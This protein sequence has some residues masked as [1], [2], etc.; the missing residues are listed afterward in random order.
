MA[1]KQEENKA[2]QLPIFE[3]MMDSDSKD[4]AIPDEEASAPLDIY[5]SQPSFTMED[6]APPMLKLLQGLSPEV[7]DGTGSPGQWALAGFDPKEDMVVVPI[8]FARRREYRDPDTFALMCKS[9][10][11]ETGHGEP[12]GSCADCPMNKWNDGRPPKCQFMYSY[13]MYCADYQAGGIVNFKRTGLAA[14]KAL[15]SIMSRRG[16]GNVALILGSK[17]QSGK[18]GSYYIPQLRPMDAEEEAAVLND[19]RAF[20]APPK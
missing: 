18:K 2:E 7:S 16:F 4:L 8:S 3:G 19:S 10:D 9:F 5:T 20:F 15:N 6:I 12:G 1:K 14:G 13:V 17:K 11:G